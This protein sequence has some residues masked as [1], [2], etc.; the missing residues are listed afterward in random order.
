MLPVNCD[1]SVPPSVNDPPGSNSV[2]ELSSSNLDRE[3]PISGE[4]Q[5]FPLA[6]VSQKGVA[7][8]SARAVKARPIKPESLAVRRP[9]VR[10]VTYAVDN[11]ER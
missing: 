3:N 11:Q 10:S 7:W 4:D 8:D 5:L 6:R 2:A 1:E 9:L